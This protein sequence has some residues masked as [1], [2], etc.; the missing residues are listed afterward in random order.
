ML[1]S[2]AIRKT[3]SEELHAR[4]GAK[5]FK[6]DT[7]KLVVVSADNLTD[8]IIEFD[9]YADRRYGAYDCSLAA[10]FKW[11]KFAKSYKEFSAWYE[12]KDPSSVQFKTKNSEQLN[13]QFLS[14][15]FDGIDSGFVSGRGPFWVANEQNLDAFIAQCVDD[16]DGKV[17]RWIKRW[18]T[19][20][21]ALDVMNGNKSLCG[22]WRDHAYFC[23]LEQVHGREAA[24][25]WVG[26]LDRANWPEYQAAQV[27]Y[28]RSQVCS[29]GAARP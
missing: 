20:R 9:C 21:S 17:G 2:K 11:K 18:F 19:W 12:L 13:A 1:D 10:V 7:A 25:S 29:V 22:T 8:F 14:V 5:W 28:L 16:L 27:E 15:A 4:L 3:V 6:L 24:C 26:G 23:L